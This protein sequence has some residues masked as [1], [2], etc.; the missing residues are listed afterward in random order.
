MTRRDL[1][2]ATIAALA[3]L[4][5]AVV[6]WVRPP[7]PD[8]IITGIVALGVSALGRVSGANGERQS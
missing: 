2:L 7:A 1:S 5:L 6:A 8:Q 4:A 3:V